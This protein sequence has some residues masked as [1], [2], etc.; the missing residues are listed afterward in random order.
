MK[1]ICLAFSLASLAISLFFTQG[2]EVLKKELYKPQCIITVNQIVQ[3][4]RAT[5]LERE[6]ATISGQKI[7]INV[8][9]FIHSNSIKKVELLPIEG[10]E[11]YYD[12]LLNLD[13]Q[14]K[15]IWMQLSAQFAHE[16]L[17]F[18]IDGV[19]YKTFI[20]E[21]IMKGV[22]DEEVKVKVKGP[23]AKPIAE[24]IRDFSV[25]NYEFFH[26]ND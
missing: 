17:A 18:I 25:P 7:W 8:N 15:L 12:L 2:C 5:R 9:P 22:S 11:N 14:G 23:F 20:P 1:K 26:R 13:Y 6:I 3:Y 19:C 10:K 16:P 24:E 21:R 4:P